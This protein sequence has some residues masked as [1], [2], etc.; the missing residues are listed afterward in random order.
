MSVRRLQRVP[1]SLVLCL[2]A[3]PA[4]GGAAASQVT[5]GDA[6]VAPALLITPEGMAGVTLGI[7]L[8]QARRW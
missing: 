2:A 8:E 3:L 1:W 6:P 4:V 7:T 5:K